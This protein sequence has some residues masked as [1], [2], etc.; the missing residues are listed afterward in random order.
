MAVVSREFAQSCSQRSG[1]SKPKHIED[2]SSITFVN[3]SM[4]TCQ[5]S[6]YIIGSERAVNHFFP[7]WDC[8]KANGVGVRQ[9][10]SEAPA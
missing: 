5:Y 2:R 3:S 4:D 8:R 6:P 1:I 10:T 7:H 9:T